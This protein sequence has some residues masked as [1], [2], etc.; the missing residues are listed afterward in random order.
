SFR[1]LFAA[2]QSLRAERDD[3]CPACLTPIDR[4]AR[5][6]F[7]RAEAGLVELEELVQLEEQAL[8]A[9][10][11]LDEAGR[12]LRAELR[13]LEAFLLSEGEADTPVYAYLNGLAPAPDVPDWWTPVLSE[14]EGQV[15]ATPSLDQLLQI[16]GRASA[17]DAATREALQAREGDL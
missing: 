11:S 10:Q 6:P 9:R 8:Q 13:S 12:Q 3:Q 16:A 2:V 7:D 1:N 4:V 5:N 15:D 14:D 17:R